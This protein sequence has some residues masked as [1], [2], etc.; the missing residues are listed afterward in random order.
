[1]YIS[2]AGVGAAFYY[3]NGTI[4]G[5]KFHHNT[6]DKV[7]AIK[8]QGGRFKISRNLISNNSHTSGSCGLT[9]GGGGITVMGCITCGT[10]DSSHFEINSN[11]IANNYSS[12]RGGGVYILD[13]RASVYNNTIVN[14]YA[15]YGGGLMFASNYGNIVIKNN[16]FRNNKS[17]STSLITNTIYAVNYDS[18]DCSNNWFE[19]SVR[20]SVLAVAGWFTTDTS[21]N[22]IGGNPGMVAPTTTNSFTEDATIADFS[23][24]ASSVCVNNGDCASIYCGGPDYPG[25]SRV[26][27]SNVDIGAFEYGAGPYNPSLGLALIAA[28]EMQLAPNPATDIVYLTLTEG[29]GTVTIS[30]IS[31]KT[32]ITHNVTAKSV[33]LPINTLSNGLYLVQWN[34]NGTKT[35]ARLVVQK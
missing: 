10:D 27:G 1:M 21:T 20:Q 28:P 15:A 23:L 18:L 31:G 34:I 9:D 19:Q 33:Q 7:G 25:N 16:I 13:T 6:N 22:I 17:D 32:L 30:D 14:N 24:L 3:S 5:N 4:T 12:F 35:A 29:S 11:I 26:S 8:C 2:Y